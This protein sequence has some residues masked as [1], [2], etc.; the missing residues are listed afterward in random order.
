V[1]LLLFKL[2]ATPLL[3]LAATLASRRWGETI[4]GFLVGLPLTSGPVSVFLALEH[5][6]TFA[7]QAT[8]GSLAATAAQAG[9]CLVYC[10]L[11]RRGAAIAL[12]IACV[13]FALAAALLRWMGLSPLALFAVAL[14]AMGLVLV[15]VPKDPSRLAASIPTSRWDLPGRMVLVTA[16]V[17]AVTLLAPSLGPQ[18]SG[19]IASFPLMGAILAVFAHL[20]IGSAAA[21]QVLRGMVAG[22]FGFG[23]FFYVLSLTLTRSSLPVAY[24]LAILGALAVQSALWRRIRQPVSPLGE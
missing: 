9:F 13:T 17:M 15:A 19:V 11:A 6:P 24:G 2:I 20:A 12:A 18:T 16:L 10:K 4:G 5:G 3:L 7:A 14:A 23:V 22:L 8:S 21:Q 1:T